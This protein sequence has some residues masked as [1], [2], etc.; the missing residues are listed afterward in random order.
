MSDITP[1]V[2]YNYFNLLPNEVLIYEIFSNFTAEDLLVVST[3]YKRFNECSNVDLLWKNACSRSGVN[4]DAVV[5]QTISKA[6]CAYKEIYLREKSSFRVCCGY[7]H[8]IIYKKS[9]NDLF[10]AGNNNYGQLGL[11]DNL[12]RFQFVKLSLASPIIDCNASWSFSMILTDDNSMILTNDNSIY[13]CGSNDR[14][15]LG[16]N[17]KYNL[18]KFTKIPSF[19]VNRIIQISVSGTHSACLTESGECYVWGRNAYGALGMGE[20]IEQLFKPTLLSF[21][22]KFSSV[23]CSNLF[24][25]AITQDRKRMYGWGMNCVGQLALGNLEL[26]Q[27]KPILSL[28]S[29]ILDK[30]PFD[31][32][33]T[34]MSCS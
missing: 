3:V 32:S 18:N 28:F 26:A 16:F 31:T 12:N 22:E 9:S 1:D 13:G 24:T 11:G 27:F 17:H 15:Q 23:E 30:E 33:I 29:S 14:G 34:S 7:E 25:L 6:L 10:V 20:D 8:S 5:T 4:L 21:K 2:G 19:C